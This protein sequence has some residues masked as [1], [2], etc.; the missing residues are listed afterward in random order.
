MSSSPEIVEVEEVE[1]LEP[2]YADSLEFRNGKTLPLQEIGGLNYLKDFK[3]DTNGNPDFSPN[4]NADKGKDVLVIADSKI[5]NDMIK[6]IDEVSASQFPKNNSNK[7]FVNMI[8]VI[9]DIWQKKYTKF[10]HPAFS[11]YKTEIEIDPKTAR[12]YLSVGAQAGLIDKSQI[13]KDGKFPHGVPIKA[14]PRASTTDKKYL[15]EFSEWFEK[16][17]IQQWFESKKSARKGFTATKT[18]DKKGK[19]VWKGAVGIAGKLH[20]IMKIMQITPEGLAS[21]DQYGQ[22]EGLKKLK[23]RL[24]KKIWE[25]PRTEE[26]FGSD[27]FEGRRWSIYDWATNP[28]APDPDYKIIKGK[29]KGRGRAIQSAK[30]AHNTW[31]DYAGIIIQYVKEL[32][33]QVPDQDPDSILAQVANKPIYAT[34]HLTVD[35]MEQMKKCIQTGATGHLPKIQNITTKITDYATDKKAV[36]TEPKWYDI[37]ASFWEDAYFYFLMSLEMG[38]RAEEAFTIIAEEVEEESDYSGLIFYDKKGNPVSFAEYDTKALH[39]IQVQIYTRKSEK[40]DQAG[41][42]TRIHAGF[43]QSPECKKLII[44]R[45]KQVQAGMQSKDPAKFG[46]VKTLNGQVYTEHSLIGSDGRYTKLGTLNLPSDIYQTEEEKKE[47][48]VRGTVEEVS[49]GR[50]K[51]RMMMK[52]CYSYV[53][54]TKPYWFERSLH[55]L[56]HVFAQYWLTLSDYNYGFVAIV[57]HWK[58]ESIVR[59]VYGK[60]RGGDI[61]RLQRIFSTGEKGDKTPFE[62]LR[63]KEDQQMSISATEEKR[64]AMMHPDIQSRLQADQVLRDK[65]FN[66]G[67]EYGGK[68]YER[69]EMPK[70]IVKEREADTKEVIG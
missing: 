51:M 8:Q 35:Q 22:V 63:E 41:Q 29:Y 15:E 1:E 23:E 42:G 11:T 24:K 66:E 26:N 57:G 49:G 37:E 44:D 48:G 54:L 43:I 62:I 69:G 4:Y 70:S 9:V 21:F 38:F 59:E 19:P 7:S 40:P 30:T 55:A 47:E 56:R 31:Y 46:I 61:N 33:L 13:E 27:K 52:H 68:T 10:Q 32:G 50:N 14:K 16:P 53:G 39:P 60:Q 64:S 58:T 5:T 65:I 25:D 67:G 6:E 34:I 28:Q 18:I 2:A 12:K 45:Y 17:E 36:I 20:K 3:V